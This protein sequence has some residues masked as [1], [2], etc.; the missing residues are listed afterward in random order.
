M[1][2]KGFLLIALLATMVL[3]GFGCKGDNTTG[4]IPIFV[5]NPGAQNPAVILTDIFITPEWINV[6]VGDIQR[7]KAFGRYSDGHESEITFDVIWVIDGLDWTGTRGYFSNYG[8]LVTQ[9]AGTLTISVRY[10]GELHGQAL[11]SV[12]NPMIDI[13]PKPPIDLAYIILPDSDIYLTWDAQK[14]L[15]PDLLGYN[16]YRSRTSGSGYVQLNQGVILGK[17]YRDSEAAGGVFYYIVTSIDL[18]GNESDFS[19]E[20]TVDK[21]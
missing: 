17:F 9:Q 18:G 3:T 12:Y 7:F 10:K 8:E 16:I 6:A 1:K 15:E 5:N 13:P 2:I 14:P 19:Y 21:R 4:Y 20:L 11:V